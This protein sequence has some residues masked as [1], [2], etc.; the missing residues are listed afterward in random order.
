MQGVNKQQ[1]RTSH[2][3]TTVTHF[4]DSIRGEEK[5]GIDTPSL[6]ISLGAFIYLGVAPDS[7]LHPEM[8]DSDP[9][10]VSG[11]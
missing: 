4:Q 3:K 7:E 5:G 11:L 6:H 10:Y 8:F 1:I 9:R 2:A